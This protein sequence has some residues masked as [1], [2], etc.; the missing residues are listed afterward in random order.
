NQGGEATPVTV[1]CSQ[2]VAPGGTRRTC[3][4]PVTCTRSVTRPV[5]VRTTTRVTGGPAKGQ[6]A[7]AT[8]I[9]PGSTGETNR[10]RIHWPAGPD[11]PP[12]SHMVRGSPSTAA[13][14]S[15]PLAHWVG[16]APMSA[17]ELDAVTSR[18]PRYCATLRY[19][20]QPGSV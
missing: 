11:Q 15:S 2:P 10:S 17:A 6:P 16:M 4:L 19:L 20:L 13:Y 5:A 7:K 9:D 8:R 1:S 12:D 3:G 18:M 14:G